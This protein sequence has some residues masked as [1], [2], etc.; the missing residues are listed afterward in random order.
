MK[1]KINGKIFKA[2]QKEEKQFQISKGLDMF[3]LMFFTEWIRNGLDN[4][5]GKG[6]MENMEKH[7]R[8]IPF[9]SKVSKGKFER[10]FPIEVD[11]ESVTFAYNFVNIF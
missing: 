2:H 11:E 6:I 1:V 5:P 10:C 9:V 3:D 8:D 4:E 7:Y